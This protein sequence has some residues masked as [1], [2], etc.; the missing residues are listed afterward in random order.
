MD[1]LLFHTGL[2]QRKKVIPQT[3]GNF[4]IVRLCFVFGKR[5]KERHERAIECMGFFTIGCFNCEAHQIIYYMLLS[6]R[7]QLFY[8]FCFTF[9]FSV[10]FIGIYIGYTQGV[11]FSFLTVQ[12][13]HGIY[14]RISAAV[15]VFAD[16]VILIVIAL[17]EPVKLFFHQFQTSVVQNT[18]LHFVQSSMRKIT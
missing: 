2:Q 12:R 10:V 1:D 16:R 18:S 13:V 5:T 9:V 8:G 15:Y 6:K 14:S 3:Q 17:L 7:H 11:F 4:N